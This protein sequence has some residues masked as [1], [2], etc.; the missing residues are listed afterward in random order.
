LLGEAERVVSVI[1]GRL[2]AYDEKRDSKL[3]R[4]LRVFLECNRSWQ[5]SATELGIHKQTLVYRIRRVEELTDRRVNS[6][7]DVAELWLALM[8]LDSGLS[9]PD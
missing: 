7:S 8:A 4:S 5:H 9:K 1:L 2:L 3:L 6:T